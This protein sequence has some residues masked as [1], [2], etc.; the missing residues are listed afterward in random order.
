M[1]QF[2]LYK[3]SELG[4][5]YRYVRDHYSSEFFK[6]HIRLVTYPI[7]SLTP[8]GCWISDSEY[9]YYGVPKRWVSSSGL[10]RYAHTTEAEALYAFKMRTKR[11]IKII[12]SNLHVAQE[13]LNT[14]E[15]LENGK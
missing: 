5:L 8:K 11:A 4:Y 13:Y 1:T 3:H 15:T 14:I 12:K 2:T 10:R 7:L 9:Q 6:A